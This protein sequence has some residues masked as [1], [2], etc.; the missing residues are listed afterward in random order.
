[1]NQ[2]TYALG[3]ICS[4]KSGDYATANHPIYHYVKLFNCHS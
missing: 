4:A 1:M 3:K 2:M